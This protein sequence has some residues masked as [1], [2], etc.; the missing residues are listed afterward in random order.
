MEKTVNE[1]G[2]GHFDMPKIVE[3]LLELIHRTRPGPEDRE[4]L[5]ETC[6]DTMEVVESEDI[7]EKLLSTAGTAASS[8]PTSSSCKLK[9]CPHWRDFVRFV[10]VNQ[11]INYVDQTMSVSA[12]QGA[13]KRFPAPAVSTLKSTFPTELKVIKVKSQHL[14][15]LCV[16]KGF[17]SHF[18][19]GGGGF[20]GRPFDRS[21]HVGS[22][23]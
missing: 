18:F 15:F 3:D 1:Y 2:P 23:H 5:L 21:N 17:W 13:R 4:C 19:L 10:Q 14:M 20:W 9:T 11:G 16:L 7:L 6:L 12:H 22:T 8:S